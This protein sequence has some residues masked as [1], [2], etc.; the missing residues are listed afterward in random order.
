MCVPYIPYMVLNRYQQAW[1]HLGIQQAYEWSWH[2]GPISVIKSFQLQDLVGK[3]GKEVVRKVFFR[4]FEL[5]VVNSMT[6]FH[7]VNPDLD[8]KYTSNTQ[9][10]NCPDMEFF[11]VRIFRHSDWIQIGKNAG[12]YGPG[13]TPYL[14][15]FHSVIIDFDRT[16]FTKWYNLCLTRNRLKIVTLPADRNHC[17]WMIL[18]WRETLSKMQV[19][20]KEVLCSLWV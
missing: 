8:Q 20:N 15:N 11:L 2:F 3:S 1:N 16:S 13:K 17:Q 6:I 5:A 10:E 18:N 9:R 19:R 14:D 12:K 7:D 4:F